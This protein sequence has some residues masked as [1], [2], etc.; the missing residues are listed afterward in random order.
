MF[1]VT[2]TVPWYI[3]PV[4]LPAA[5]GLLGVIVGAL[6]TASATYLVDE[7]R[8]AREDV[9]AVR[10]ETLEIMRAARV[11]DQDIMLAL[12][13]TN[14]AVA[15]KRRIKKP[16]NP[17]AIEG[18]RENAQ[19]IAPRLSLDGWERL[20]SAR[21]V[22]ENLHSFYGQR[23]HEDLG[24]TA[25]KMLSVCIRGLEEGRRILRPLVSGSV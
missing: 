11:I 25:I 3:S 6:I 23:G 1:A 24:E 22:M 20:A 4:F 8:A 9:S 21:L 14:D 13:E 10:K 7:R 16:H 19:I 17:V 12:S 2:E 15:R 18:W 5:S